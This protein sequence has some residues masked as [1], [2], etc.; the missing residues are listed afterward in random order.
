MDSLLAYTYYATVL[1]NHDGDNLTVNID[2][3]FSTWQHKVSVRL[4]GCNAIE[5]EDPGGK[6]AQ[7]NLAQ[8]VPPGTI[9]LLKSA[10]W[11][12]YRGR[13]DALVFELTHGGPP[14]PTSL[15]DNL[16]AEGWAAP[17]TGKGPKNVPAWPRVVPA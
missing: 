7:Q 11:D 6:E 13:I 14:L 8:R 4:L 10:K 2:L 5:L 9:V 15:T 16:I 3:G 12:K 17:Y 1:G